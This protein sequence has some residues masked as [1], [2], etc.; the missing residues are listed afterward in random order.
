[1]KKVALTSRII[2]Y[3]PHKEVQESLDIRWCTLL[4]DLGF[5]P[6]YIPIKTRVPEDYV[7]RENVAGVIFT[8]GNVLGTIND[9]PISKQRDKFE[10]RVL[11]ICL[12][13]NLPVLGVCRGMQFIAH[14]FGATFSSI[15]SHAGCY[16]PVHYSRSFPIRRFCNTSEEKNSFHNYTISDLPPCLDTI[17]SCDDGT[18]EGIIH[19]R[20]S[21][22]IGIM[23]HPERMQQHAS[24]DRQLIQGL[25][26]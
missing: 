23:W 1:M 13:T 19:K 4:E 12:S 21:N 9:D 26:E 11:D 24:S 18:I 20:H 2:E 5:M 10:Q 22:I 17:A 15:K 14:Y 3:G 6:I 7:S 8:G 25:F 16:H